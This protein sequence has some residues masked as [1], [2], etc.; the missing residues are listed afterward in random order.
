MDASLARF[1]SSIATA[2]LVAIVVWPLL[3]RRFELNL[4]GTALAIV[5]ISACPALILPANVA[6]RGF[7]RLL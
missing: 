2:H 6:A 3:R 7:A 5:G 1:V 4:V